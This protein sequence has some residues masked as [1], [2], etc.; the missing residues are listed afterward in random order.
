[1]NGAPTKGYEQHVGKKTTFH[2]MYPE[3]AVDLPDNRTHLMLFPFKTL[4]LN[5]LISAFTTGSIRL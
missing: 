3:S 5:W 4:D 1:M 2:I